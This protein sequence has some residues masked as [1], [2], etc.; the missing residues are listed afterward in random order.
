MKPIKFLIPLAWTALTMPACTGDIP[1]AD[2]G[3]LAEGAVH[4][5][6][7]IAGVGTRASIA[8]DGSGTFESGD[9]WGLYTSVGG[10]NVSDNREY[11]YGKTQ[12]LWDDLSATEPVTFSAHFPRQD[13]EKKPEKYYFTP[14]GNFARDD[15]L[16]ATATQS[17]GED[18]SL[19]FRHLMH[20]FT[21]E[22]TAGTGMTDSDL[23]NARIQTMDKDGRETMGTGATVNLLT[24][25]VGAPK[26]TKNYSF[27]ADGYDVIVV[28]QKLNVSAPWLKITAGMDVWYYN[29]PTDLDL[30]EPG[31]QITL[32]GGECLTLNLKL[33]K[34][35]GGG[36]EVTLTSIGIYGWNDATPVSDDVSMSNPSGSTD[37]ADKL[38]EAL[39]GTGTDPITVDENLTLA[40]KGIIQLGADHTL[41]I[42]PNVTLTIAGGKGI[43]C[44]THTL[45]IK[46]GGMLVI[47]ESN[48]NAA[49]IDG[50]TL[51]LDKVNVD[52]RG[53]SIFKCDIEVG[54]GTLLTLDS[55]FGIPLQLLTKNLTVKGV[56]LINNFVDSGINCQGSVRIDGGSIIID[57]VGTST[58]GKNPVALWLG[59]GNNELVRINRGTLTSYNDGGAI[60]MAANTSVKGGSGLFMREGQKLTTDEPTLVGSS[61]T[62]TVLRVGVYKWIS[63]DKAFV[64]TSLE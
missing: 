2:A 5:R 1:P 25:E 34:A 4:I 48:K 20:R 8:E 27:A 62:P 12:L 30:K 3:D 24:G 36:N 11:T 23:A 21:V 39:K 58:S 32:K 14:V 57:G 33:D 38:I 61:T 6:A 22:L 46:G 45:T 28:P 53:G 10:A 16:F 37:P 44:D 50:G 47:D 13:D 18:V 60:Y 42:K 29:V 7:S 41:D 52:M 55:E 26:D 15:L 64:W 19:T 40:Q 59:G 51:K 9:V 49:I 43:N 35:A 56:I 31:E 54:T 63:A 17:K